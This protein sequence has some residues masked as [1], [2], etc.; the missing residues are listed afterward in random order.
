MSEVTLIVGGRNYTLACEDGQEDHVR[1]MAAMIDERLSALGPSLTSIEAKNLLFAG[2]FLADELTEA[3]R[4]L[5]EAP[6]MSLGGVQ[7]APETSQTAEKAAK[8]TAEM[9]EK[10]ATSLENTAAQLERS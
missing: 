5:E 4:K 1:S 10:I 9:L 7:S 6:A 8:E 2:L 3:K